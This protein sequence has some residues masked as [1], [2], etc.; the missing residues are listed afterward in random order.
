MRRWLILSAVSL[1]FFFI[2]GT[3]FMSLGVVLFAMVRALG[4]SQTEAGTGFSVLAMSCCLSSL[5]PM[6][7]VKRIGTR[8]TM[9]LGGFT[10]AAGFLAAFF[11]HGPW[12]FFLAT[13]LMGMGFSLSANIPGVYLLALWFPRKTSLIIGLY[14]MSG[15]FGG[16]VGP[17]LAQLLIAAHGW[18]LYWLFLSAAAA[19]L[20]LVCL[21][22]IRDR[23]PVS[24]AVMAE[25]AS[26]GIS[27]NWRYR[28]AVLT[29]QFVLLA[30]AMVLTETCVT[31]L[32]SAGVMHFAKFGLPA[33][34]AA[35]ILGLQALMATMGKGGSGAL[36]D[37]VDP[38]LLLTGGLVLECAGMFLLAHADTQS[39]AYLFA[40]VFGL[41]W[42]TAYLTV[43]V[44]LINYFGPGTGSSV[45]SLV[46]LLT[47]GAALG[48]AI[49]GFVADRFGTFSLVFDACGV[50]LLPL[51]GLIFFMRRP[52]PGSAA[53]QADL[54]VAAT[55]MGADLESRRLNV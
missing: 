1:M 48:P 40:V 53:T 55:V 18:R 33:P 11:T 14:L 26:P 17:P 50:I 20:G 45:L 30:L 16:V 39:L 44:L 6:A 9:M 35:V 34:F 46:W 31:I 27:A 49:A 51:I 42:G 5:L 24:G 37:W 22:L 28:D 41:G 36:G 12:L 25:P 7:L 13:G 29:Y 10:I 38:R 23:R 19:A 8:W 47:A 3:T 2:T 21:L 54:P 32:H 4:W 52:Q 43:T 15:A